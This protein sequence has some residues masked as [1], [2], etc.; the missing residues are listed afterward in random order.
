MSDTTVAAPAESTESS[1]EP[2]VSQLFNAT[3]ADVILRS[4]DGV[5]FKV[6][7]K[8][9][10]AFSEGFAGPGSSQDDENK[11]PE[12]DV[13]QLAESSGV[14]EIV[15]QFMRRQRHPDIG[16][17]PFKMLKDVAEA[18]EKYQVFSGLEVC[19]LWMRQPGQ[20]DKWPLEVLAYATKH[21]YEDLANTAAKAALGRKTDAVLALLPPHMH[22]RW[23]RY[24]ESWYSTS[25]SILRQYT[26]NQPHGPQYG[27]GY[28]RA[29]EDLD[30]PCAIWTNFYADV[31]SSLAK[32]IDGLRDV[33]S[34]FNA[35]AKRTSVATCATCKKW[36]NTWLETSRETVRKLVLIDIEADK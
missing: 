6:Y 20:L 8:D 27:F 17:L 31:A 22:M 32:G 3:D 29:T 9:L 2:K 24:I 1:N 13:V 7:R 4:S 36:M 18:V 28:N 19:N 30:A 12:N 10:E 26:P 35:S 21:G 16:G 25:Q 11:N 33:N 5:L 15:L 34:L 23:L 14:I